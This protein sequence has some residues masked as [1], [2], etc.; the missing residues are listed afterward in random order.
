M[1]RRLLALICFPIGVAVAQPVLT[2]ADAYGDWHG[3][4]PGVR[5]HITLD[6]LPTPFATRSAGRAPEV[7]ERPRGVWPRVPAG[8]EVSLFA[9]GLE[10]PRTMRTAPNGDVFLAES[11]VGAIRVFDVRQSGARQSGGQQSR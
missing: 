11:G 8:F 10:M 9:S 4:A 3:D 5:R 2:G 7:V 1:L 6:A